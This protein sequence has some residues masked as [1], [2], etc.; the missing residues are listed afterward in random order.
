MG[1][2]DLYPFVISD[3]TASKLGFVHGLIGKARPEQSGRSPEG[4]CAAKEA[5]APALH[6]T[7]CNK[8]SDSGSI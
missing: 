7:I 8:T 1:L 2:P 5:A 3:V 4:L 6:E